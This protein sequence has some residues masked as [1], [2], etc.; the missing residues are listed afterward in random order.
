MSDNETTS[1]S[2]GESRTD[3]DRPP[4]DA[5]KEEVAPA[6]VEAGAASSEEVS[7]A[8]AETPKEEEAPALAAVSADETP[9]AAAE[10][11]KEEEA[12]APAAVSS[13]ET[14]PAAAE[15]IAADTPKV[16]EA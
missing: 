15:Q 3:Q 13:D 6:A 7:T 12:P 10:T 9:P 16:E 8:V 5:S 1:T 2:I 14:P 4:L 11:P